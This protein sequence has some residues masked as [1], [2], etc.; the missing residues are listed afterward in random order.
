MKQGCGYVVLVET[1]DQ[2][3][4][5]MNIKYNKVI[6]LADNNKTHDKM[7]GLYIGKKQC[8]LFSSPQQQ[9]TYV[10]E[11]TNLLLD[12]ARLETKETRGIGSNRKT[13]RCFKRRAPFTAP[14]ETAGGV[15]RRKWRVMRESSLHNSTRD[16][17]RREVRHKMKS[18]GRGCLRGRVMK[19]E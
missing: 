15:S 19:R 17:G 8:F 4:A 14:H 10:A 5:S 9:K 12:L 1:E 6:V 13:G 2:L 7:K 11:R 18:D 16:C 3:N